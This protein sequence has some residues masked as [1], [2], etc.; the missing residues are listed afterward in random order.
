MDRR[1]VV[2][3][4]YLVLTLAVLTVAGAFSPAGAPAAAGVAVLPQP[5]PCP[6]IERPQAFSV[7]PGAAVVALQLPSGMSGDFAD[8]HYASSG[9]HPAP[10]IYVPSERW[11]FTPPGIRHPVRAHRI[12]IL[13]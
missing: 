5:A 2:T 7:L 10:S 1:L 9:R 12:G 8:T 11:R 6:L 13:V 3:T 4:S